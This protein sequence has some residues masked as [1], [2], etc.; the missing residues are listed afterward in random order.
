VYEDWYVSTLHLNARVP[1][2]ISASGKVTTGI[3]FKLYA[4]HDGTSCNLT[5]G[6]ILAMGLR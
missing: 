2:Q 6:N 5:K 1:A 4:K 3:R